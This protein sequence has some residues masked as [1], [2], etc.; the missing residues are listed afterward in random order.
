MRKVSVSS[1]LISFNGFFAGTSLFVCLC[2]ELSLLS[3]LTP[4]SQLT[5][6][7]LWL[8]SGGRAAKQCYI[9][10]LINGEREARSNRGRIM[11]LAE[12]IRRLLSRHSKHASFMLLVLFE[13]HYHQLLASFIFHTRLPPYL[14]AG[15]F[16]KT[17]R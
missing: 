7:L 2:R 12:K 5:R 4:H 13:S 11:I 1:C 16:R 9:K 17:I 10:L 14:A 3:F 8:S 15:P 6:I